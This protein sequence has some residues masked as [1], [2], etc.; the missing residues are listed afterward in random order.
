M[1][2]N[3]PPISEGIQKTCRSGAFFSVVVGL[4]DDLHVLIE[5]DEEALKALHGELAEVAVQ[6]LGDAGLA[7]AEQVKAWTCSTLYMQEIAT[8]VL[9]SRDN[10]VVLIKR[11][12]YQERRRLT[13]PCRIIG[14]P[15][16]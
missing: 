16:V 13:G 1:H 14:D 8:Y 4:Y 6:H 15:S 3:V 10:S 2:G 12:W 11:V 7:D 9:V 5:G